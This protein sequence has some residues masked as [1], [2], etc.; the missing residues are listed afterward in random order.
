MGEALISGRPTS[1][2]GCSSRATL[3]GRRERA[4]SRFVAIAG[5]AQV[6]NLHRGAK[7]NGD[8]LADNCSWEGSLIKKTQF[9]PGDVGH[10]SDVTWEWTSVTNSPFIPRKGI[11]TS[12]VTVFTGG[13]RSATVTIVRSYLV[14][15]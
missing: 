10:T 8:N 3:S 5:A 4:R 7:R 6:L 9:V 13:L 12:D 15:V 11:A 2:S 14:E 1:E